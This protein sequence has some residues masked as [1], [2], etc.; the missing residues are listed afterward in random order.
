MDIEEYLENYLTD[1]GFVQVHSAV[2]WLSHFPPNKYQCYRPQ[3]SENPDYYPAWFKVVS[4]ATNK[5]GAP[6]N[7]VCILY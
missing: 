5:H 2:E 4:L 6:V 1:S 3:P 7:H